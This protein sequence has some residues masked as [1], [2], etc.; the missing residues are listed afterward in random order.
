MKKGYKKMLIIWKS[1]FLRIPW[2]GP[3]HHTQISIIN[4]AKKVGVDKANQVML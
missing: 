2:E 4:K 3:D 1:N